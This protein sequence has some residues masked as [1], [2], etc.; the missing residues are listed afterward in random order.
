MGEGIR[1][2]CWKEAGCCPEE[3]GETEDGGVCEGFRSAEEPDRDMGLTSANG[4][5]PG[6]FEGKAD[7]GTAQLAWF[8]ICVTF[9][10]IL[11]LRGA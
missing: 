6:W 8:V 7:L 9:F 5:L 3:G 2:D 4:D 10:F 11:Y 1:S